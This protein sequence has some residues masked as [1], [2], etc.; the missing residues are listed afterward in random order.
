[1]SSGCHLQAKSDILADTS[2]GHALA[3]NYVAWPHLHQAPWGI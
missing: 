3:V 2:E 1:M